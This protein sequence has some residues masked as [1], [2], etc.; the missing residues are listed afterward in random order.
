MELVINKTGNGEIFGVRSVPER[1]V[2]QLYYL[3]RE[4]KSI[5]VVVD[6]KI[7]RDSFEIKIQTDWS[8]DFGCS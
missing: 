1:K 2:N 4:G 6:G 5:F 3:N 8:I 7:R